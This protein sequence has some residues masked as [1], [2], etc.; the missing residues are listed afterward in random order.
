MQN[1]I[2]VNASLALAKTNAPNQQ[3][4]YRSG[5]GQSLSCI[6]DANINSMDVDIPPVYPNELVDD[7]SVVN[8]VNEDLSVSIEDV[9]R[10]E[11]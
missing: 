7:Q 6:T 4:L 10:T 1:S 9:S 8:D 11:L 2:V 3:D 5:V